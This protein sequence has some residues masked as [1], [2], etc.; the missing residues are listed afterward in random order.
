MYKSTIIFEFFI[1]SAVPALE[2]LL[3]RQPFLNQ[4]PFDKHTSILDLTTG[5]SMISVK[6]I[7]VAL[8]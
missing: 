3:T 1:D 4:S 5:F 7:K 6:L 8:D 2:E